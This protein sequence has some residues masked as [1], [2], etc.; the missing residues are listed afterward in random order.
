MSTKEPLKARPPAPA[1]FPDVPDGEEE[2]DDA[3]I[4]R[5]FRWSAVAIILIAAGAGGA[6][7]WFNRTPPPPPPKE[8]EVSL[9]EIR[10]APP[11]EIPSIPFTDI[12]SH[13]GID[14]DH[15]NGASGDK[16][17]PETMGGGC[18]FF[19]CDSDGDQDVLFVNSQRWTWDPRPAEAPATLRLYRNDGAG[20]FED[21]TPGSGLDVSLYGMGVAC[22]D[23]D[24]DGRV[25]VF[26]SAVGPN[27]LFR[28]VGEGKFEDVTETAGVAGDPNGWGTSCGW[29]DYDKDA[30]LD[31]FVCNYVVWTKEIDQAQNFRLTGEVRAYGRPQNFPGTY[32]YLYRNDGGG[33]FTDVSAE[34][35]VQVRNPATGTPAG[36]SLGL[37]F[38]DFDEDGRLD[39]VVANDTVGN[40]LFHNQGNGTFE[41]IGT[42]AGVAYDQDGTARGAM[43]IDIAR[44]RNNEDIGIA[45]GNF[46]NEMT[47][48]YVAQGGQL[49]FKD[50][51][52]SNGLGPVTRLELKF[53]MVF[54]DA[55]LDGRLDL[56]SANGH[57]EEDINKVQ[58]SQHYE[59][60]PQLFW[61]C[62]P[63][64]STE[65][66]PAKR[67]HCGD[68]FKRP[69]VGRGATVADIDGD[70]DLD[71][72]LTA[73]GGKPRLLRNDQQLGNH[74]LR[75]KLVGSKS[76]RDAIGATVEVHVG[77]TV[78]SQT[79]RP[80]C[81]YLSQR[82]LPLTFGLGKTDKIEKVMVRWPSGQSSML[83]GPA[84]DRLHVVEE[85]QEDVA[86][87][88]R[89]SAQPGKRGRD[90]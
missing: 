84:V 26:I 55:D 41:E 20:R 2:R 5:A 71:V 76:N 11:V 43:G 83:P 52:V 51:A 65:F 18:A 15:E 86:R 80:T 8:T 42:L 59:Q 87:A 31:L 90:G 64:H 28:N 44:F 1:E 48:L 46:A 73:S 6:A 4:G 81:S 25:D 13:A 89:R 40:F 10:K 85:S 24:N 79:V 63:E 69:M 66:V 21:A 36:K 60:P 37:A 19:D 67:E 74:W 34:A 62:G 58:A 12:T 39:V 72:L 45:I 82:E 23:Y 49:Q 88:F 9:P 35:G 54:V 50:D 30:D 27:R 16:L 17:L 3:V 53:G 32:P 57:L 68:D 14:F 70:G 78:L 33:K 56:L 75:L 77:D 7:W 38:A 47:A 29:F 61:N 22:G